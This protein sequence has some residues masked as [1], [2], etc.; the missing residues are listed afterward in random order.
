MEKGGNDMYRR[1]VT[2]V[3]LISVMLCASGTAVY[4]MPE[5]SV[6][7]NFETGIVDISL[8][9]YMLNESGEET[10]WVDPEAVLPGMQISKIPRITNE[11]NSCYVRVKLEF[12][13]TEAVDEE[14][15]YGMDVNWT[16][17][18]DGYYYYKNILDESD[19]VDVFQGI[20]IPEDLSQEEMQG[21]I[22]SLNIDA[23]AIQAANFTPDFDAV[24]PW[25]EVEIL[26]STAEEG[27]DITAFKQGSNLSLEIEYQGQTRMISFRIYRILCPEMNTVTVRL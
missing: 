23:D 16:R 11:G 22:F 5:A 12:E 26:E 4:A 20:R 1:W 6:E 27:Y 24:E 10:E 3:S 9:E 19:S 2:G 7:N 21:Q 14:D 8:H 17:A 25:G 13:G 18:E 15:L